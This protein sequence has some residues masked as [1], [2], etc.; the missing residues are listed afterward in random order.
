M[1]M[2]DHLI[3]DTAAEH[4]PPCSCGGPGAAASPQSATL[5]GL[6]D[7]LERLKGEFEHRLTGIVRTETVA[8]GAAG[9]PVEPGNLDLLR[10]FTEAMQSMG[11]A[12]DGDRVDVAAEPPRG[13]PR[14]KRFLTDGV[15]VALGTFQEPVA[16]R[17][18]LA[19]Q[20][21]VRPE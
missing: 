6:L 5:S 15:D 18:Y 10:P 12:R 13:A 11:R 8:A 4:R 16:L 2:D 21:P 19:P 9:G 1:H 7:T 14:K 20:R 17:A 3:F